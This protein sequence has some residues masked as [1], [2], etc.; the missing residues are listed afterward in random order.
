MTPLTDFLF[1]SD[2]LSNFGNN[3]KISLGTY[4]KWLNLKKI[5]T[6]CKIVCNC[7]DKR[8]PRRSQVYEKEI[9][10]GLCVKTIHTL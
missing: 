1:L 3:F 2:F 5:I 6:N 8:H 10:Q 4:V 9:I 7:L